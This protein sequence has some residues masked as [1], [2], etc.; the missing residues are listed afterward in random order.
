M[1]NQLQNILDEIKV[2]KDSKLLPENIKKGVQIFD[3]TGTLEQGEASA[4]APVKLFETIEDMQNDLTAKEN[5]LAVVYRNEINNATVDS[6][7]QVAKFQTTVVLPQAMSDYVEVR[8]RA[9]DNSIMFDCWGSL[10]SSRFMME[11]YTES[12]SIRIQYT[13][14][15]GITYTRTD[16]GDET[17]DFGTEIKYDRPEYW[18]DVIGYFIQTGG[19][20]FEGM[21]EY[22]V[23][24]PLESYRLRYADISKYNL[25][26]TH[27]STNIVD[28]NVYIGEYKFTGI[29]IGRK[30]T[31]IEAEL[32]SIQQYVFNEDLSKLYA[33]Y[34]VG[35]S[36]II[37]N[38]EFYIYYPYS[39]RNMITYDM[40]SM[41]RTEE[42][43]VTES[44]ILDGSTYSLYKFPADAKWY[45]GSMGNNNSYLYYYLNDKRQSVT[46]TTCV[47]PEVDSTNKYLIAPTQLTLKASNE[48][49]PE[50]IAYG[51][52]GVVTG[53]GSIYNNIKFYE[54]L[55]NRGYN[56]A[57]DFSYVAGNENNERLYISDCTPF[58]TNS[59]IVEIK[60]VNY[61]EEFANH[62]IYPFGEAYVLLE[63]DTDDV[64]ET[65]IKAVKLYNKSFEL[66]QEHRFSTRQKV[67]NATFLLSE[68]V[69][70][71]KFPLLFYIPAT[72][73]TWINVTSN[74]I[75]VVGT[76]A[77]T[78]MGTSP[79]VFDYRIFGD[80]LYVG[81]YIN[82]TGS[83]IRLSGTNTVTTVKSYTG[84]SYYGSYGT[85]RMIE[86]DGKLYVNM[87][88]NYSS[89]KYDAKLY[90][91]NSSHAVS[92]ILTD[93]Y[94]NKLVMTRNGYVYKSSTGKIYKINTSDDSLIEVNDYNYMHTNTYYFEDANA[95]AMSS[96]TG[97]N[98]K[99]FADSSIQYIHGALSALAQ[100]PMTV[101]SRGNYMMIDVDYDNHTMTWLG[102][103]RILDGDTILAENQQYKC[104]AYFG[105]RLSDEG[106]ACISADL[107]YSTLLCGTPMTDISVAE[108]DEINDMAEDILGGVK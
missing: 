95:S 18:N 79:S 27:S 91:I 41:T 24:I 17:I 32:D 50:K 10:D 26:E 93:V 90:A 12:G 36:I 92:T 57:T 38:N 1:S 81:Y 7:F 80:S 20:Y 56:I 101:T 69:A 54:L 83:V 87:Y 25:T 76:Y 6:Q 30:L 14:T 9:V 97:F 4:D 74:S 43:V 48:L 34:G 42:Q 100:I 62:N 44:V 96:G 75:E 5:D 99:S 49:L 15:D 53:D 8:Y 52:N 84:S 102:M 39:T 28:T 105:K 61:P 59:G 86:L 55:K 106:I 82:S 45:T 77:H 33:F 19:K 21:F 70:N 66:L 31:Q 88:F 2:E 47:I 3:I 13:S 71:N 78:S 60:A 85:I 58:E 107:P 40:N 46:W 64:S 51:K 65:Y 89:T 108:Y 98:Y 16:G 23:D 63:L 22:T 68:A 73:F 29:D 72:S 35:Q 37:Y 104:T 103:Y 11:C 67:A 94:P